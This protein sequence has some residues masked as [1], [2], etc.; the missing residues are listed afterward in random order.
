MAAPVPGIPPRDQ[1][2]R[3]P[4]LG[5]VGGPDREQFTKGHERRSRQALERVRGDE[6]EINSKVNKLTMPVL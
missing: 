2:V 4:L 6:A 5:H 3:S 1:I